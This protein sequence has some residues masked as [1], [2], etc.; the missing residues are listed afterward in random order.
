MAARHVI[1]T[2]FAVPL[3]RRPEAGRNPARNPDRNPPR[4]DDPDWL[5]LRLDLFRRFFVPSVER[6]GVPA[7][8]LCAAGAADFV[9]E[10][11]A[12]LPWVQ[13]EV[14]D[15]WRGG[16]PGAASQ[17]LTRLDSDDAIHEGWFEAVDRAPEEAE[18]CIVKEHL[19][20]DVRSGRLHR[21]E[22]SE[23]SPLA[24]FRAGLNPYRHDH[25]YLER[26]YRTHRIRGAHLLQVVHG[27]NL[28]SRRPKPWRL[29]RRV[30][31]DRL[32]AFGLAGAARSRR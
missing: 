32:E 27:T 15:D 25:K 7:V 14:Q 5:E 19:R 3:E 4:H 31:R 17:I 28:S 21:Y 24:A 11:T 2:R 9:A 29:D 20:L 16:W 30:S 8:L 6:L 10:R 23:P 26:H 1:V 18:V 12:D 13:V 22:R